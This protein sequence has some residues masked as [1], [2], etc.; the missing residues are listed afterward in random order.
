MVKRTKQTL[1]K[2]VQHNLSL[3]GSLYSS[4]HSFQITQWASATKAVQQ[5][6]T[7]L[8]NTHVVP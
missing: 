2:P 3:M 5:C 4:D 1:G 8:G 6:V 7:L